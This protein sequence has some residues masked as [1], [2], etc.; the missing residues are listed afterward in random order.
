MCVGGGGSHA[1]ARM[2]G[3]I[4]LKISQIKH[5]ASLYWSFVWHVIFSLLFYFGIVLKKLCKTLFFAYASM[6]L[7]KKKCDWLSKTSTILQCK[8]AAE[9]SQRRFRKYSPAEKC[10]TRGGFER[11]LP[12]ILLFLSV[13]FCIFSIFLEFHI[14]PLLI[15]CMTLIFCGGLFFSAFSHFWAPCCSSVHVSVFQNCSFLDPFVF[16]SCI[17]FQASQ[18]FQCVFAICIVFHHSKS[19]PRSKFCYRSYFAAI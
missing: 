18:L 17:K 6:F 5:F 12:A 15:R 11:N 19:V 4:D 3:Q 10:T 14:S 8:D 9:F 1:H 2:H 7:G 13:F 16:L